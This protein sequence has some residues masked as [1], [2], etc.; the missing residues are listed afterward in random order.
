MQGLQQTRE[1]DGRWTLK[2]MGMVLNMMY[3]PTKIIQEQ[4]C[5]R[6][7]PDHAAASASLLWKPCR[8]SFLN[9]I[10]H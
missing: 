5:S 9:Q 8:A 2:G 3:A 1:H 6:P 4:D 7:V 10:T